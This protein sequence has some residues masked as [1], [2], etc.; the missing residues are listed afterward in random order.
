MEFL[1]EE[2]EVEM[3]IQDYVANIPLKNP[4]QLMS[5]VYKQGYVGQENGVKALC[6]MAY[7]HIR[8]LKKI[9]VEG[10]KPEILPKKQNYLLIG[11]TGCGKTF[12][13]EQLFQGLLGIPTVIID[14]TNYSETGYVGQDVN[15]ILT[16][17]F[18][19]ANYS[20]QLTAIG[21]VCLDEIDKISSG[22]NSAVFAGAGTTKDV[23]GIGVQR[24]LL[25]MLESS[26]VPV[27]N[28]LSHSS[29][30]D[31]FLIP[32]RDIA[33]IGSGAF[34]GF[35]LV[36]RE[37]DGPGL[38]F[39]TDI[40]KRNIKKIAVEYSEDEVNH[41]ASFQ[42]YGFL[43]ELIA[44][45]TR[46]IPFNPLYKNELA[47]I[48]QRNVISHYKSDFNLD[49]IDLLV[50]KSAID[51]I[52]EQSIKRETGAR[53]LESILIKHIEEAAFQAFSDDK[54][55]KLTIGVKAGKINVKLT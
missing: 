17:L 47:E 27:S 12:L 11:P 7:R 20:P 30:S 51:I 44:R 14:I 35:K 31:I 52:V 6:L 32:T 9:Y 28:N 18:Y 39:G 41:I 43:P 3:S 2:N 49:G 45:F 53:G 19:A 15:S 40:S 55:K 50:T 33:F 26:T 16:R 22:Q 34:S 5:M 10:V 37:N 38:G 24:E 1:Q 46:I 13:I 54:C 21:V 42:Q 8:R 4:A 36:S 23:T 48:L 25:K 29:Y